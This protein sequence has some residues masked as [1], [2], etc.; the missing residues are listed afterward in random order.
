MVN[1]IRSSRP[2]S[3]ADI[4]KSG[5]ARCFSW[6]TFL[7]ESHPEKLIPHPI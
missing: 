3:F 6:A 7:F 5:E 4:I 2:I 1:D